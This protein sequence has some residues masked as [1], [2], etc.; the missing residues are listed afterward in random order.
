MRNADGSHSVERWPAGGPA[1]IGVPRSGP[2]NAV[3]AF[4]THPKASGRARP[5]AADIANVRSRPELA[6][7]YVVSHDGVFVIDAAGNVMELG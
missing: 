4:H 3:G 2:D 6:P 7:H 1:D 5:S